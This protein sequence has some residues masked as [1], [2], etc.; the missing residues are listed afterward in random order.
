MQKEIKYYPV[1]WI[2]G[3]KINKSHFLQQDH[4][5]TNLVTDAVAV[6]TTPFNYGLL[7][8]DE[9]NTSQ[10][11]LWIDVDNQQVLTVKLV[12]CNAVSAGGARV[13]IDGS[14]TNPFKLSASFP[15]VKADTCSLP[16]GS[17]FIILSV[18]P[19]DKK[20]F[21]EADPNEEPPRYPFLAPAYHLFLVPAD[22]TGHRNMGPYHLSLG[23]LQ[24]RNNIA[25]LDENYIPPCMA[26]NSHPA[27]AEAF[28]FY[29]NQ[30][31]TLETVCLQIIKKIHFRNQQNLLA[32]L[33]WY[34]SENMLMYLS[35]VLAKFRW[36]M[37][38]ETPV[39]MVEAVAGLGR[40]LKNSIDTRQATGKEELIDYFA[41]W[42]DLNQAQFE[43][44]ISDAV[45]AE[46]N[47][48]D[49]RPSLNRCSLF[50]REVV[51]LFKKL[52][53]L[54]YIGRKTDKDI[55]VKEEAPD[56][57]KPRISIFGS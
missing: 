39:V 50:V 32:Q 36:S 33:V 52:S 40:V 46:Y 29:N 49:I 5:F 7:P 14:E 48:T 20:P 17:Y 26:V 12:S 25:T 13:F 28:A 4:A 31:S 9:M 30:L 57:A 47:H 11:K 44:V 55:F 23:K 3:M 24:L 10:L 41:D 8:A 56:F 51:T 45:N 54:D 43:K 35:P 6:R 2:D 42:L 22:E 53:E 1:N 37:P 34:I 18:N 19:F 15:V 27:L 16:E 21:G 38:Y